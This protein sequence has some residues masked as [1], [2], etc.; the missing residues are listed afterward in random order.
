MPAKQSRQHIPRRG[1][2][3]TRCTQSA[4]LKMRTELQ[5]AQ[6]AAAEE[7]EN[8]STRKASD[9]TRRTQRIEQATPFSSNNKHRT[10]TIDSTKLPRTSC[11]TA[12]IGEP[13]QKTSKIARVLRI[14]A[15]T[16]Q[17]MERRQRHQ[18]PAYYIRWFLF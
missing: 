2:H 13:M 6:A 8:C 7:E 4:P 16:V 14:G 3:G 15:Y 18:Q 11:T 10:S 9:S 5:T 1:R 17:D 12:Q